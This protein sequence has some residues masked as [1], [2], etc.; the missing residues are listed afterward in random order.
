MEYPTLA[1]E[2]RPDTGSGTARRLRRSGF[3]PAVIY[4]HGES[5]SVTLK[6]KTFREMVSVD[7]YGSMIVKL[8]LDGT[9]AGLALVKNVQ[10]NTL[11]KV[12]MNIDLQRV[13]VNEQLNISLPVVLTGEPVGVHA[14][15]ILEIERHAINVRCVASAVPEQITF[16]I[17]ELNIGDHLSAGQ[18][19]LP[20]GCE[21][22]DK[23]DE[24]IAIVHA[25][26]GAS[27]EEAEEKAAEAGEA[28]TATA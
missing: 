1:V 14:G 13:S 6:S 28:A 3:A 2:L 4:G 18:L 23:A 5:L 20:E 16:N 9:D 17:S 19:Q 26:A 22:M 10:V 15:G 7:Q 24:C 8:S 27:H 21:L 25:L 12:I 11:H